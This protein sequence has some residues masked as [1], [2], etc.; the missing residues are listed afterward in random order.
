MSSPHEYLLTG[1]SILN[2]FLFSL[3]I[4]LFA[5]LQKEIV[6]EIAENISNTNQNK[7]PSYYKGEY[8]VFELLGTGAFGSVYKVRKRTGRQSFLA[9]KEVSFVIWIFI[10]IDIEVERP[11]LPVEWHFQKNE[12]KRV[13]F[14]PT[15][16]TFSIV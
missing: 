13:N 4:F 8:A 11:S 15:G 1:Y 7:E 16:S 3:G 10:I 14:W 2:L 6:N 12:E 9:L 5:C